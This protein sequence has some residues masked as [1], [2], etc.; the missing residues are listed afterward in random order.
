MCVCVEY[1]FVLRVC[2][3]RND[4]RN[5]LID[6]SISLC[7]RVYVVSVS[8]LLSC[9]ILYLLSKSKH[10]AHDQC[11]C[12]ARSIVMR[13]YVRV[14]ESALVWRVCACVDLCSH[15]ICMLRVVE[16]VGRMRSICLVVFL[17]LLF[18]FTT[19]NNP[20]I[21]CCKQAMQDPAARRMPKDVMDPQ[22][23]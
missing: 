21:V 12:R 11:H 4:L 8:V 2:E 13:I 17:L 19:A 6:I 23:L 7:A 5:F 10:S 22:V 9:D 3:R 14:C 1:V 18:K 20:C 15:I 16:A